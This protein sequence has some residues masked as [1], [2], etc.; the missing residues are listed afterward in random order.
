MLKG[1]DEDERLRELRERFRSATPPRFQRRRRVGVA[2][3][4]AAVTLIALALWLAPM[5]GGLLAP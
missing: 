2:A 5:V 4:L 3:V 1:L